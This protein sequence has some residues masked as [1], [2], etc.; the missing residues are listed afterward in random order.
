MSASVNI[1]VRLQKDSTLAQSSYRILVVEDHAD[2]AK[3]MQLMIRMLGHSAE[4]SSNVREA[5]DRVS[6]ESFDLL[7]VDFRLPDGSGSDLLKTL[8]ERGPVR[9]VLLTAYDPSDL[10]PSTTA[11]FS[12][13]LKKPV[14][15]QELQRTIERLCS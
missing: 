1:R 15:M 10:G 8:S 7:L 12:A 13:C 11:G 4:L 9:A 5:V 6:R 2:A 3:M 14:E